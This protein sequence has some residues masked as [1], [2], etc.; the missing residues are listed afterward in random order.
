MRD[1]YYRIGQVLEV[2]SMSQGY[3][4]KGWRTLHT[5]EWET[6][7]GC[8]RIRPGY[9]TVQ[10]DHRSTST[11]MYPVER[12]ARV[13]TRARPLRR[14]TQYSSSVVGFPDEKIHMKAVAAK[15]SALVSVARRRI[16]D[17]HIFRICRMLSLLSQASASGITS[18]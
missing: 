3:R 2:V 8:K 4:V 14:L 16:G 1:R 9:S 13:P 6:G 15:A 18:P 11:K 5:G 10:G 17:S 7:P 12:H